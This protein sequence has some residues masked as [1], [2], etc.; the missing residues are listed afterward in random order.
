MRTQTR[1]LALVWLAIGPVLSAVAPTHAATNVAVFNFQMKSETPDWRWLEKG[2]A[3]RI[4][5]DF[6]RA[7]GSFR[8]GC[9]MQYRG[10]SGRRRSPG[11]GH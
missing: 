5:T 7:P 11:A 4:A 9:R 10:F 6:V 2:L 1:W 3:D 8:S